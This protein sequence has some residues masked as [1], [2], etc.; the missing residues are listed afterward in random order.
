MRLLPVLLLTAATIAGCSQAQVASRPNDL[1]SSYFQV[2]VPKNEIGLYD[3]APAHDEANEICA[4]RM[5]RA[6]YFMGQDVG[7][8]RRMLYFR[9]E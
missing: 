2:M 7:S 8:D 5:T 3:A 1:S 9:C 6:I 4:E